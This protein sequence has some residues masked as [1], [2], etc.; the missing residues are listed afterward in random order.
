M[1]RQR[2]TCSDR[3]RRRRGTRG[4][5][6]VARAGRRPG[7]S[8]VARARAPVLVSAACGRR[9]VRARRGSPFRALQPRTR[10][11]RVVLSWRARLGGHLAAPCLHVPRWC[12]ALHNAPACLRHQAHHCG[13]RCTHFSWTGGHVDDRGAARRARGRGCAKSRVRRAGR[14]RVEPAGVRVG[15]DDRRLARSARDRRG[16]HRRHAGDSAAPALRTRGERGRQRRAR[17][18]RRH[19]PRRCLRD[20]GPAG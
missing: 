18:E 6:C 10:D 12:R 1:G 4:R 9:T 17:A 5:A 8:R 13:A 3:R 16:G 11:G 20:G 7:A 15:A 19:L 14:S 2:T